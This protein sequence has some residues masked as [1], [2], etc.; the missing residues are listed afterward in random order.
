MSMLKQTLHRMICSINV[1]AKSSF[2]DMSYIKRVEDML[3]EEGGEVGPD[4]SIDLK[5]I[6]KKRQKFIEELNEMSSSGF[7]AVLIFITDIL[8]KGSYILYNEASGVLLKNAFN[9]QNVYE[10]I[11][12]EGL[13]SRKKQILP[14]I[15]KVLD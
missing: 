4:K 13:I 5:S 1:P 10:G 7:K 14:A 8:K 11:F 12:I 3:K 2:H 9:L 6:I 15:L